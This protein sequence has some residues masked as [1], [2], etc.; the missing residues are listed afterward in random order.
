[1]AASARGRTAPSARSAPKQGVGWSVLLPISFVLLA[2]VT[3][4]IVPLKIEQRRVAL[5]D[6]VQRD[7]APIQLLLAE[8]VSKQ[9]RQMALV[10]QFVATGDRKYRVEYAQAMAREDSLFGALRARADSLL[11]H[12]GPSVTDRQDRRRTFA[13][14]FQ[15]DLSL[16]LGPLARSWHILLSPLMEGE[17][18]AVAPSDFVENLDRSREFFESIR[19]ATRSLEVK[20][21]AEALAAQAEQH[22]NQAIRLWTTVLSILLAVFASVAIVV[23]G[24][25]LRRLASRE[26]QRRREAVTAR[27]EVR[28]VLR[29]T[30]DG[31]LGIDLEGLC[32]FLNLAGERLLGYSVGE[33]RGRPVHELIHHTRV[34]GTA[35]PAEDCPVRATLE[36]GKPSHV[37]DDVLW[38]KDGTSFPVQLSAIPMTDGL[39]VRGVVLTFG[40]MTEIRRTESALRDAVQA[41]DDMI[42]VVSHDLRNPVGT[43]AAAAELIQDIPLTE[44][45]RAEHLDIIR[46]SA[47]RMS[48]LIDDLLD[49]AR[50]DAGRLKVE[51][52]SE[53]VGDLLQEAVALSSHLAG[54]AGVVVRMGG[55]D[56][57]PRV[58]VDRERIL[59]VL[60]NLIGNAIQFTPAGGEITLR[61]AAE[62]G[63]VVV[64]VA[65]NGPGVPEEVRAHL[66]DRFWRGGSS[67]GKGAGLGLAIVKGLVEAHSG[68]VWVESVAGEGA[69]FSFSLPIAEKPSSSHEFLTTDA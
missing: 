45:R 11:A 27:R 8:L 40:D 58:M 2:L 6:R 37:A 32:T 18:N 9:N 63:R 26:E 43:V 14:E 17:I 65:D 24:R 10:E 28:A 39:D 31:V 44:E 38:R 67:G 33:M 55:D 47:D 35:R 68:E 69:T 57:M 12:V 60:A 51:P 34:D 1:M 29:G 48:R 16:D 20:V 61:A 50:L 62:E 54:Q 5:E 22:R 59:Q 13:L 46:R 49:I 53:P 19:E 23:V 7:L 4:A 56:G 66:F 36:S 30:G 64:S 25:N 15:K 42:A 41:R 21:I 3:L 52:A